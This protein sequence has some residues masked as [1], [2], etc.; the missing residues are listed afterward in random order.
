VQ[1]AKRR[2][3]PRKLPEG[4][5]DAAYPFGLAWARPVRQY[6][7]PVVRS[8]REAYPTRDLARAWTRAFDYVAE[9]ELR[10]R[11]VLSLAR[12]LAS[13][14][15]AIVFAED[16]IVA[17]VPG[18]REGVAVRRLFARA[19]RVLEDELVTPELYVAR[20]APERPE[21]VAL[22]WRDPRA[23]TVE[24]AR[25]IVASCGWALEQRAAE[26]APA[27][28]P[29]GGATLRRLEQLVHDARRM[30]RSFAVVYVDVEPAQAASASEAARDAVAR[31]LRREVR[32]NDH[33]GHLGGDAYLALLAL[34]SGESEAYPAAQR[35]LRAAANAAA[36]ACANVGVAICPE[37]GV[38]PQD[39]VEKAGAAA[40]AAASVGGARPYWYRES[41]GRELGERAMIRARLCDGDPAT[42]LEVR[43]Q[44]IFDARSGAPCA[45][46]AAA[47]WREPG[48]AFPSSP[49]DYLTSEPDRAAREALER[50]TIASAAAAHRTW[51]AVGIE[52]DVQLVLA[53]PGDAV[54]DAIAAGFGADAAMRGVLAEILVRDGAPPGP[55]E[56]FARRLHAL[57]A[58]VGVA[59]ACTSR[60]PF[61]GEHGLLDF[62][63]VDGSHEVRTL[64]ELALASVVTPVVIVGGVDDRERGRRLARYGATALSGKG[65]AAPM[66]LP[67][68]VRWASEQR[69][70]VGL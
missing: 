69:G 15:R 14:E 41:A 22:R 54:V 58:R 11:A 48:P 30:K 21:R 8:D 59:A 33:L 40:M 23:D 7:L 55:L 38:Q 4:R 13:A 65:L 43:Y 20:I 60:P 9:P 68:L 24:I 64:A 52:L 36:D 42:L 26:R 25:A 10:L 1:R 28:L 62:V 5:G 57:G 44:P 46:S 18:A 66:G 3:P 63:T 31:R 29:D 47:A 32:A 70:S 49:L 53:T 35:L 56:S 19:R 6:R 16:R 67:E 2:V 61:D 12:T 27:D 50:W 39:L 17:A 45:V 37:D 51:R 34:E